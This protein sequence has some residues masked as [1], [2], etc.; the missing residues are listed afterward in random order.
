MTVILWLEGVCYHN[1]G[2]WQKTD[3]STEMHVMIQI[4]FSRDRTLSH[5]T[6]FG[7]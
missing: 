1:E 2:S 5:K 6:N 4:S 7:W 3:I